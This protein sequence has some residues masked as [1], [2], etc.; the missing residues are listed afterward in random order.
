MFFR[1]R[2]AFFGTM[3]LTLVAGFM[4]GQIGQAGTPSTP[5]SADDPIVTK[6]Y[7]DEKLAQ[8]TG[9]NSGNTGSSGGGFKVLVMKQGQT[10]KASTEAGLEV[11]VRNGN[12]AAIQGQLGGLSDVTGGAD[13]TGGTTIMANHLLIFARNDGRGIQVN[14]A[15]DTY[16]LVRGAYTLQ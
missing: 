7:V 11:I 16:V 6:S 5:G 9:G 4:L 8:L 15:G 2:T 1:K 3:A 13:L 14:S 12:V 10:L